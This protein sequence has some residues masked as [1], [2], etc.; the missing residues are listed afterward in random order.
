MKQFFLLYLMLLFHFL[1]YS[2]PKITDIVWKGINN[3]Y[4]QIFKKYATYNKGQHFQEFSVVKYVKNSYIV[5]A[6]PHISGL[7]WQQ[8][9]IVHFTKDTLI[10]APVGRDVFKLSQLN[11]NNQYVFI[12]S[13][14]G[15]TFV[16]LHFTTTLIVPELDLNLSITLTIDSTRKSFVKLHDDYMNETNVVTTSISKYEHK[17]LNT[18][19]AGLDISNLPEKAV[20]DLPNTYLN[21]LPKYFIYAQLECCNSFFE[22][23]YNDQVKTYRGC[24]SIPFYHPALAHFLI[25][26]IA[27]KS[28]QSGRRPKLW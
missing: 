12:N 4:L 13:L 24:T 8:Y 22:V 16:K 6:S 11:E 27:M 21:S 15:F 18:I 7:Y 10:L 17:T 20:V 9:D 1:A 28:G 2:Q 19:L 23:H 14:N 5:L 26:Y 25:N 3:E